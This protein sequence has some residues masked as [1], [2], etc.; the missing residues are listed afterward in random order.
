MDKT[1]K[2][3]FDAVQKQ[4]SDLAKEINELNEK[5]GNK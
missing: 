4:Y 1:F 5:K 3:I 2:S